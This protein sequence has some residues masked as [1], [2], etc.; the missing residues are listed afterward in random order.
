MKAVDGFVPAVGFARMRG[1]WV[2]KAYAIH[3]FWQV[4]A[5]SGLGFKQQNRAYRRADA[6][7]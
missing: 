2:T 5:A 3:D 7:S 4:F 1:R 6:N